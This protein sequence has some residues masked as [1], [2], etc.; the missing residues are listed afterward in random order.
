[1]DHWNR[2]TQH[3]SSVS[4]VYIFFVAFTLN[5]EWDVGRKEEKGPQNISSHPRGGHGQDHNTVF[6]G[7]QFCECFF[8][9]CLPAPCS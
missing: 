1:M 9:F 8:V 7:M 2:D 6:E 5:M 3:I 4:L